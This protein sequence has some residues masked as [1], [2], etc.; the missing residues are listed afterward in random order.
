MDVDC[1]LDLDY[2]LRLWAPA[3]A[4][5][6]IS[7]VVELLVC[8]VGL[9]CE[10]ARTWILINLLCHAAINNI[11]LKRQQMTFQSINQSHY[12]NVRSKADK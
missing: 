2:W 1:T 5:R 3:S 9:T 10:H 8:I 12:F 4:S 7:A 6:A 11:L